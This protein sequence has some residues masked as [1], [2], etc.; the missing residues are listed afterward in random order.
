MH[1]L[2][3]NKQV[4]KG[5]SSL[6]LI[7]MLI[8][9]ASPVVYAMQY[10]VPGNFQ[11]IENKK[12]LNFARFIANLSEENSD[13][14]VK[15]NR[16]TNANL[17]TTLKTMSGGP[18]Q[19]ETSGYTVSSTDGM[20]D[21][22]TGDLT[23][24]IPIAD[25][26]GYALALSYSS[27]INMNTEASWVGLG[28]DL[29]VGA[30]NRTMRGLPDEFN[31]EQ[32]VE[33]TFNQ[34]NDVTDGFKQGGY[35]GYGIGLGGS[36]YANLGLQVTALWGSYS[37]TYL[38]NGKTFDFGLQASLSFGYEKSGLYVAP[39]F[40]LGYSSDTKRGVGTNTSY[41]LSAGRD[42]GSSQGI[43]AALGYTYGQSFQS[44]Q[45]LVAKTHSFNA[46]LGYED[47]DKTKNNAKTKGKYGLSAS[48]G[49]SSV[50]PYG[51]ITSLPS[52]RMNSYGNSGSF[53]TDFFFGVKLGISTLKIGFISTDYDTQ[54]T[55]ARNA[56]SKIIQPA[57]GY[58]HSNKYDNYAVAPNGYGTTTP[59]MDFNRINDYEYSK[60]MVNLPFSF[61]TYDI[62]SVSA[63][64]FGGTYRGRRMD[65]GT[66]ED[67]ASKMS[68]DNTGG[69]FS[70]GYV[71]STTPPTIGTLGIAGST[72]NGDG[73]VESGEFTA[74]NDNNARLHFTPES[75]G[76]KFD[77]SVYFKASGEMT[78]EDL[79]DLNTLGGAQPVYPTF[80]LYDNEKE[81]RL[82]G[83]IQNE[84]ATFS[85]AINSTSINAA[86]T[87]VRA[88]YFAPYTA[89]E[90]S[91]FAGEAGFQYFTSTGASN[92]QK[93][94]EPGIGSNDP[95]YANHLSAIETMNTD[96]T[97]YVFGIPAYE[98]KSAQVTFSMTGQTDPD[99]D[100]LV[101]YSPGTDNSIS[102]TR[103][104]SHYFDKSVVPA[105][106]HSF[107]LTEMLSSDYVDRTDNGPSLD[108]IGNYYHFKYT[109]LFDK[110][111]PYKW[112]FPMGVN[113]ATFNR[114]LLGT[115]L[116]DMA[117]YAYGEKEVWYPKQIESKNLIAEFVLEDR[118]DAVG[119]TD[120]NGALNS[121]AKLKRLK[122]IKIY[123]RSERID[124]VNGGSVKPLQ[125]IEFEYTYELCKNNPSNI[126]TIPGQTGKLTLTKVRSYSGTS[127]EN[128]LYH[129]EFKYPTSAAENP[130]YSP[131]TDG[132]GKKKAIDPNKPNDVFPY[133]DQDPSVAALNA[134]AW[135]LKRI[136]TPAN[137]TIEF[138]Y[139]ADSYTTVQN[140]KTMRHIDL[141]GMMA[142][143]ELKDI[144]DA[145][146]W[147]QSTYLSSSYHN[148]SLSG[149]TSGTNWPFMRDYLNL[150]GDF[151][152]GVVPNNVL[153]YEL[154]QSIDGTLPFST[155]NTEL[156]N[157]YFRDLTQSSGLMQS[158]FVKQHVKVTSGVNELVPWFAKIDVDYGGVT[159]IG[160]LPP[161]A[162]GDDYKYGYVV[163][164]PTIV[165][166]KDGKK[167]GNVFHPLQRAAIEFARRNLAD[168]VYGA[169]A[170][171]SADQELI[172]DK[173][174]AMKKT[175][176]NALMSDKGWVSTLITDFSTVRV[177]SP[178]PKFGGNGRVSQITYKDNWE[179]VSGEDIPG[180]YTW[181][182]TYTS[183][184]AQGN[185]A[186]EPAGIIDECALYSWDTY[187]NVL[188]KFPD[189]TKFNPTPL[190]LPL[191]PDPI[192]GYEKVKV[193]MTGVEN[194]GYSETEFITSKKYP[195]LFQKTVINKSVETDKPSNFLTGKTT[196]RF[197]F[198][199]GFSIQTNDFHG[200]EFRSS[201]YA[202]DK[203]LPGQDPMPSLQEQVTYSY[204][205]LATPLPMLKNNGVVTNEYVAQ[206]YDI[207]ADTK[208]VSNEVTNRET[209]FGVSLKF[210]YSPPYVIPIPIFGITKTSR[211]EAF[212]SAAVVKHINRSAIVENIETRT[213]N[214][215]NKAKNILYDYQS[216]NVLLSSLND[217]YNDNKDNDK[218]NDELYSMV[219]PSHWYYKSLRDKSS[220]QN[221]VF[222]VTVGAGG[223]ISGMDHLLSPG[224]VIRFVSPALTG[225]VWI[226]KKNTTT[227]GD[228]FLMTMTGLSAFGTPGY[229]NTGSYTVEIIRSNR[230]N[231]L[232]ET[233]ENFVTKKD[234][235]DETTNTLTFPT[236]AS[237]EIIHSSALTYRDRNN[238]KCGIPSSKEASY[239]NNEATLNQSLNPYLYGMRGDL[240]VDN[241]YEWQSERV[242][243]SH[244][245]RT[246]FDGAYLNFTPFYTLSGG[247]WVKHSF[248]VEPP[249]AT[250]GWR[251]GEKI[252]T[253]D[254]FGK[255]LESKNQLNLYSSVLYGYN[256]QLNLLPVASAVNARQQEIAFEGFEDLNYYPL[257][258]L[259]N[260]VPH[261]NFTVSASQVDATSRHSG[262]NSLK[263]TS[264]SS[265]TATAGI[266]T[267]CIAEEAQ[268]GTANSFVVT[269][270]NCI[271]P[272][273]PTFGSYIIGAW[274]KNTDPTLPANGT[275]TV[276][277]PGA[278][279][280]SYTFTA[281]GPVIDGWQRI[282]GVFKIDGTATGMT[283]KL[284]HTSG[285]SVNFD[286]FRIH[287]EMASM[288]TTVYDAKTLLPMA[289]HD[290]N[291]FTMFYNYDENNNLVRVRVETIEGIKTVSETETG[292]KKK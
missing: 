91:A 113:Q 271:E 24:S 189:E 205:D 269:E 235:F 107:L 82:T 78:P 10:N 249:V 246:R 70:L 51:T 136:D 169:T 1:H 229:P 112:R 18:G 71:Q 222:N 127:Q 68:N 21:K 219:Y 49:T 161:T 162:V 267:A 41:G 208:F 57:I 228:L 99:G 35:L 261:L 142:V 241:T 119:V 131:V 279:T 234:P 63:M 143:S 272:F 36:K 277:I 226:A 53:G 26:E 215:V 60:E 27:N 194:R 199:Q 145:G 74:I 206:E 157:Q 149:V 166:D 85:S 109:R 120:E 94:I 114:G 163:L 196:N 164:K 129:Y 198:S 242:Q 95:H 195:V 97:R 197:A 193:E 225:T 7:T 171:A 156:R 287:P 183:D 173:S 65:V 29:N 84:N 230:E 62:F 75:K 275:I 176:I 108:D 16:Q 259:G 121:A 8:N 15:V 254:V 256:A 111:T 54:I 217:E 66:Y 141:K 55:I 224:D 221:A 61:Q 236:N 81:V 47:K 104:E 182:Y 19:S 180:V 40:G 207:H 139:E 34:A 160:I 252:S 243:A 289:T 31:G 290:S 281:S 125:T 181:K 148:S 210:L 79:G 130:D 270:C 80:E 282:E 64:G 245:Y 231:R 216:G 266:E 152:E 28:W 274:V 14:A 39:T 273:K 122:F 285:S 175:D 2:K 56:D 278:T 153:I 240:V 45:G 202:Y 211:T 86:N 89:E 90:Y 77:N 105:Y 192:I 110:T 106:P 155:A 250:S 257:S 220:S 238:I 44:R 201:I 251:P 124:P 158:I 218:L 204:R 30:V 286:D 151:D 200:K 17:S 209:A 165:N 93:R 33:R 144:L 280:P 126:S 147:D 291:N 265:L 263:L 179:A 96:G 22:F 102:N 20:V 177:Y 172:L 116:D 13:K 276:S 255:V 284:N 191:Y 140:R 76:N 48:Y 167:N 214:S 227:N 73:D 146:T 283:I 188:K 190:A 59:L 98:L 159:A 138:E 174:V 25:I 262:I 237:S 178:T 244:D 87:R 223:V 184:E 213:F 103:G 264:L 187:V 248:P 32:T 69:S 170:S 115:N 133:T 260:N 132:W 67:A 154:P 137:G 11:L 118:D 168:V 128:S 52:V 292:G 83:N 92:V 134:K 288:T 101:S 212:Y 38:G 150:T 42:N 46:S 50:L 247:N 5:I 72:I 117:N 185:A 4:L 268:D 100:G 258:N 239:S 88:N 232:N 186:F 12:E 123:N 3:N 43:G 253:Y 233:M 9:C 135:K 203:P 37:N 23:Y 6:L 58:Y